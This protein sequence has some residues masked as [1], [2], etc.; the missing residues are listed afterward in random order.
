[1]TAL[2]VIKTIVLGSL[3]W[4]KLRLKKLNFKQRVLDPGYSTVQAVIR[5]ELR[6]SNQ[7]WGY[8]SM[9]NHAHSQ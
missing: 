2:L 7:L 1:M 5:R 6:T 9:W 8:R 4:L 3:S